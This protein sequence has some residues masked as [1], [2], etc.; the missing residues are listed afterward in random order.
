MS[1]K[2]GLVR[3]GRTLDSPRKSLG[4]GVMHTLTLESPAGWLT[5]EESVGMSRDRA[6]KISTVNRCVEVLS[7]SMAVLPVYI[8][9]ERTKERLP[10]HRLGRVLWERANEAMTA[11]DY[12]RLMLCNELLRGNA[13]AWIYRD[14]RTGWPREL[15]PLP[16]DNMTIHVDTEGHVWYFFTHPTTGAVT[17]LRPEEVLHYKAYSEDGIE[18]ISVLRRAS[19]TLSTARAAQQYENSTWMSGGQ[20]SGILT[21]DA[22]LGDSIEVEQADGTKVK[23]DPKDQLRKSWEA[24]HRGPGNAFRIAVLDLGLKYQPISMT[25]SDAQFV[26]SNEIRVADICR[27]FGVPL[28]LAY[29][30]KQSY[31]SNEQNGIEFVNYTLLAYETQWGQEDTY[32][33]LL[34]SERAGQLRIKRNLKV[35]LKGDTAAQSA[36]YRT[37]REI[38]ALN[39]DEIRGLED[40][41]TIPGGQEYYASWNYGPLSNWALLSVIRALGNAAGAELPNEG[42]VKNE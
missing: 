27:F 15:I 23:V 1:L 33:L 36:W 41:G 19:L 24:V 30:G 25:N 38:S 5:G 21:T 7:N 35:F 20:P 14:P 8:M 32:K 22:D 12:Q 42:D 13:Y 10:D 34:P 3:A 29:A 28:H 26:E 9:N 4:N 18:G 6:M 2:R 16:P 37:M 39:A 11:F 17:M 40:M 31:Q